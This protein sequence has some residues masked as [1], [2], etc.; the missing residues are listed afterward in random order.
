LT[1]KLVNY[2]RCKFFLGELIYIGG[3]IDCTGHSRNRVHPGSSSL[4]RT[5]KH[6]H[7]LTVQVICSLDGI[8]LAY[9]IGRGNNNDM[10]MFNK[11]G[12]ENILSKNGMYLLADKGYKNVKLIR[13]DNYKIRNT[14]LSKKKSDCRK[15]IWKYLYW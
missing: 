7:F 8:I 14:G 2:L 11:S 4:Y 6:Q 12:T 15:F 1:L 9:A 3:A 5:D 13:P 10:G